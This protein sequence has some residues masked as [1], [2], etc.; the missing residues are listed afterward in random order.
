MSERPRPAD[1]NGLVKMAIF[2]TGLYVATPL[3]CYG[4]FLSL[5]MG[6]D[7]SPVDG[8]EMGWKLRCVVMG[9][10]GKFLVLVLGWDGKILVVL[11]WD[12]MGNFRYWMEW[13]MTRDS[14]CWD[15]DGIV[16]RVT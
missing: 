8:N 16:W 9:W 7:Q 14:N 13:Y 10:D 1:E 5:S 12:G 6:W 2:L 4:R 11:G 15:G 3:G